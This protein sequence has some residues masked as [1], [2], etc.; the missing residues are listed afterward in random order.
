MNLGNAAPSKNL[1]SSRRRWIMGAAVA[2]GGLAT[3]PTAFG[4]TAALADAD[5]GLSKTAEAI[6]QETIF[7]ASP[8]RIYDALT[9]A[10]QFQKIELLSLALPQLDL[11]NKP[12]KI[13][14]EPGGTFSLFGAYIVGRQIELVPNQR[15]VQAWREISWTPGFTPLRNSSSPNREP[16][17]GLFLT[18]PA[19]RL[20]MENTSPRDGDPT[21]GIAGKISLL[22]QFPLTAK[23]SEAGPATHSPRF[24]AGSGES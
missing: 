5:D 24:V 18:T 14:R 4:A 1:V 15:I 23:P 2:I 13:N 12:A 22:S 6:H 9:D 11:K 7:K 8:K 21:I 19:S 17:P 16:E 3:H 10:D 20:A